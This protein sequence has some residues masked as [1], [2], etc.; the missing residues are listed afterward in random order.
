MNVADAAEPG[1]ALVVDVVGLVVEDGEFVDLA[2]QLAQVG[3]AV[4]RLAAG[5]L[6]EGL[7]KVVAQVLVFERG[8]AHVTEVDAVNVGEEEVADVAHHTHVVL[9]MQRELEVVAPVAAG[10][11][12]VGQHRVGE[13]DAQTVEIGTQAVEHDDVRRDEQEVARERRTGLVEA[14]ESLAHVVEPD[15][16]LDRFALSVVTAE[17]ERG[18]SGC[19]AMRSGRQCLRGRAERAQHIADQLRAVFR[20]G[21]VALDAQLVVAGELDVAVLLH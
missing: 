1:H 3:L 8:L 6:A 18:I 5:P 20:L 17:G 15:H 13:E 14:V 4:G 16:R 12:V 21:R 7:Q 2:D 10:V 9:Q 19:S 11:A